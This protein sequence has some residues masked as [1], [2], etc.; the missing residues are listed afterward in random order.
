MTIS[1]SG[2]LGTPG[3][4]RALPAGRDERVSVVDGGSM[5]SK[6]RCSAPRRSQTSICL[7]ASALVM[8]IFR[9]LACSATGIRRVS[10]PTS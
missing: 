6:Q 5:N 3:W 4:W 10:T 9:G 1:L 8:A 7:G 2:R